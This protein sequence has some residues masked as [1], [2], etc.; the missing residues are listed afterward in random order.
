MSTQIDA[1][2]TVTT[3]ITTFFRDMPIATA[4]GFFCK[5]R[6]QTFLV[7]NWHVVTG[8]HSENLT[9]LNSMCALPDRFSFLAGCRGRIGEW[10]TVE[11]PL[12]D[13]P[14][15]EGGTPTW[16][17]HPVH[18]HKVDAVAIPVDIPT[19][20]EVHAIDKVNTVP[21]MLL[22]VSREVFVL[23]YPKGIDGG[24][25]F[26]IWKRASIATEPN[27]A[28]DGLPKT[29]IDTAT[30]EGMSGGPVIAVADGPFDVEGP[31]P[32][33]RLPGRVYRFVGI[34]S[35][36]LGDKEVEAQLGIVWRERAVSDIFD[37]PPAGRSSF[38]LRPID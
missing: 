30:R 23:G 26:P 13:A 29:L 3:R 31:Q 38:D 19:D 22:T 9:P 6:D 5:V 24:R 12:Y 33:Y 10:I 25:G 32:A 36:R 1:G 7:T 11:V 35:G 17:E 4:T 18:G 8:R 14:A 16:F 28:L 21:K 37:A 20:A 34:Y 15:L 2:S 27:V